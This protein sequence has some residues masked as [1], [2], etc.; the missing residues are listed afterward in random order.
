MSGSQLLQASGDLNAK[1]GANE[2]SKEEN[3]EVKRE[4]QRILH[5]AQV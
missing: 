5:Y 4:P 3:K 1:A 2:A